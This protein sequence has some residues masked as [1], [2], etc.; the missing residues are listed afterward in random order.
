MLP[1]GIPMPKSFTRMVSGPMLQ[2][3]LLLLHRK[4]PFTDMLPWWRYKNG[5]FECW[6]KGT[7]YCFKGKKW[8]RSHRHTF[9]QQCEFSWQW[10]LSLSLEE[11]HFGQVRNTIHAAFLDVMLPPGKAEC[12]INY[13]SYSKTW[14]EV[15]CNA[16]TASNGGGIITCFQNSTRCFPVTKWAP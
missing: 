12:W 9:H 15:R 1:S 13:N 10:F 2:L 8:N 5:M 4:R 7:I 16:T 14:K 3:S 6:P 11:N